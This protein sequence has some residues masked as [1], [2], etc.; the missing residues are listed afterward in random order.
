[1][2]DKP[3]LIDELRV[4]RQAIPSALVFVAV[5]FLLRGYDGTVYALGRQVSMLAET[6]LGGSEVL[7]PVLLHTLPLALAAGVA[8]FAIA[9]RWIRFEGMWSIIVLGGIVMAGTTVGGLLR[10][11]VPEPAIEETTT[12]TAAENMVISS[13]GIPNL[14]GLEVS[15]LTLQAQSP[16]SLS[17]VV[18]RSPPVVRTSVWERLQAVDFLALPDLTKRPPQEIAPLPLI[19]KV[20]GVFAIAGAA[21]NQLLGFLIAYQPRLFLAAVLAGAW[22]GWRWQQRLSTLRLHVGEA[23]EQATESSPI[24]RAA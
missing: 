19:P 14:S 6:F 20:S 3:T 21:V 4:L 10:G 9:A 13:D 12:V 2:D 23:V 24:R 8:S 15:S 18:M 7:V 22:T 1:M 17:T 11:L 5:L 16:G